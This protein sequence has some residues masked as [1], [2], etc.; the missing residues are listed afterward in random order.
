[1]CFDK[2]KWTAWDMCVNNQYIYVYA[3]MYMYV[4]YSS[5]DLHM[6]SFI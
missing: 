5:F 6:E 3:C 2:V 1:M 4:W